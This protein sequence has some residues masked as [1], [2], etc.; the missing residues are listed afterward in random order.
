VRRRVTPPSCWPR[1]WL[2]GRRACVMGHV[3]GWTDD[4]MDAVREMPQCHED[5]ALG[6]KC[7]GCGQAQR[8]VCELVRFGQSSAGG[9]AVALGDRGPAG[10]RK[11]VLGHDRS[12]NGCPKGG[13]DCGSSA[14][15]PM[16]RSVF[17]FKRGQAAFDRPRVGVCRLEDPESSACSASAS[18][19]M[20]C[21]VTSVSFKSVCFS[22]SSVWLRRSTTSCSPR[23]FANAMS[24]P[25]AA[26][27]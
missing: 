22:S 16:S 18:G 23:A 26:I 7:F 6:G 19:I 1:Q 10:R 12:R 14:I 20:C 15:R 17:R 4:Q 11:G 21:S 2:H 9:F 8:C 5:G 25:Y 13:R 27:S 3:F 24:V